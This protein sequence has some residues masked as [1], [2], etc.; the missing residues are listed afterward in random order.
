MS[1]TQWAK[2]TISKNKLS[3]EF[4]KYSYKLLHEQLYSQITFFLKFQ[5]KEGSKVGVSV[6]RLFFQVKIIKNSDKISL[7]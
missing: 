7:L 2:K 4:L 3:L 1:F 5:S 6:F